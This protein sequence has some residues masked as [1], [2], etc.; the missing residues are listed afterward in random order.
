MKVIFS[1]PDWTISG[2]N[3]FHH[4]LARALQAEGHD[5]ELLMARMQPPPNELPLPTDVPVRVLDFVKRSY[6]S[7]WYAVI[8]Y[9]NSRETPCI[10]LPGYDFENSGVVSAVSNEIGVVGVV[11]SD[12]PFHYEHVE[13]MGRYWNAAVAVSGFLYDAMTRDQPPLAPRSYQINC[14]VPSAASLPARDLRD[15]PLRLVYTGRFSE[16]QK[17]VSDLPRIA[18][19]LEQKGVPAEWTLIGAGDNEAELRAA[20][21]TL[22]DPSKVRFA[23]KM[24]SDEVMGHYAGQDCFL[25]TSNFEGLPVSLMEAMGQGV[26]PLVTDID[27]G[28][29]EIVSHGRNGFLQP[30]GDIDAFAARLAELHA[31]PSRRG[32]LHEAAFRT[33]KGSRFAIESVA[34][35]YLE[36]FDRVNRDIADGTWRRPKPIRPGTR[37]GDIIPPPHLQYTPDEVLLR[38]H[39]TVGDVWNS[40]RRRTRSLLGESRKRAVGILKNRLRRYRTSVVPDEARR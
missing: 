38:R 28:I 26:I 16:Y 9:L 13:R 8:G 39:R 33:I 14:G 4:N 6:F 11:H 7:R 30:V 1:T 18:R 27:S 20:F 17:R 5:V 24:S 31:S 29:P 3:T 23:G 15:R 10:Y 2:V 37:S 36:V 22:A 40:L 12:D 34:E 25:L 19:A 35:R 21:A 32:A